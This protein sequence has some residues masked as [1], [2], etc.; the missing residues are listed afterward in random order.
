MLP[1]GIIGTSLFLMTTLSRSFSP[2]SQA[3]FIVKFVFS[4][5]LSKN[6]SMSLPL[7]DIFARY[8]L[9]SFLFLKRFIKLFKFSGLFAVIS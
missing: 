6:G 3:S 9:Y 8:N 7:L 1:S 2:I 4:I 5:L